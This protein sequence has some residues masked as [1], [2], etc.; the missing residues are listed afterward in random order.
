MGADGMRGQDRVSIQN[1]R[2]IHRGRELPNRERRGGDRPAVHERPE[3]ERHELPGTVAVGEYHAYFHRNRYRADER[4]LQRD[5]DRGLDWLSTDQWL[6]YDV[7]VPERGTYD[8]TMRVAA[9]S[10]FGGGDVGVVVGDDP[11]TRI[12]FDATGGWYTWDRVGTEV[13]LPAGQ[14]TL[15][16]VVFEGG[17]KLDEFTI[18]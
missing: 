14:Y 2:T 7:D 13:E 9:E 16:L 5:G 12:G 18:E 1:G 3:R 6:A 8:L 10:E 4:P 17:W 11:V 15:R